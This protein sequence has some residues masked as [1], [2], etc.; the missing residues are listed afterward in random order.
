M[1]MKQFRPI[2]WFT[3]RFFGSSKLRPFDADSWWQ[4]HTKKYQPDWE[5]F[6]ARSPEQQAQTLKDRERELK[7][8]SEEL[9]SVSGRSPLLGAIATA[10]LAGNIVLIKDGDPSLMWMVKLALLPVTMGFLLLLALA[11]PSFGSIY[12]RYNSSSTWQRLMRRPQDSYTKLMML[13][14]RYC[15][16]TDWLKAHQIRATVLLSIGGILLGAALFFR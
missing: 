9:K 14:D 1:K 6:C 11:A 5:E 15:D 4:G 3:R 16:R 8:V 7:S 12:K 2:W 13:I 10:I